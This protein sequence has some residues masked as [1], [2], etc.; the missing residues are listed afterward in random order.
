MVHWTKL[1]LQSPGRLLW[2]QIQS[3]H[4]VHMLPEVPDTATNGKELRLSE[5]VVTKALPSTST[6]TSTD[7][8]ALQ[9]LHKAP[10]EHVRKPAS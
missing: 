6:S 2:R 10:G 8:R 3:R 5:L 9:N 4:R 1:D 7:S